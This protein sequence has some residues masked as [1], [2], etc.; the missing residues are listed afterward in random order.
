MSQSQAGR[1][2]VQ[3]A[4]LPSHHSPDLSG[5]ESQLNCTQQTFRPPVVSGRKPILHPCLLLHKTLHES[6]QVDTCFLYRLYTE[7]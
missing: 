1:P 2:D 6:K 7:C 3:G 4:A 5:G